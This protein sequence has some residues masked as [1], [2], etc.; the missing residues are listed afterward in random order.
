L[1]SGQREG[2]FGELYGEFRDRLQGDRW[3]PDV[4]IFETEKN[5]VVRLEL[6][7]VRGEE[8]SVTVDGNAL[9]VCGVRLAPEPADVRRLHQMEIATGPFDRRL[10]IPIAFEREGVNAHLADGFLTVTLPKRVPVGRSVTIERETDQ[11]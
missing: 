1:S 3:Q 11:E 8:L 4:D 2:P 6:A 7:G 10:R 5:I 9:R